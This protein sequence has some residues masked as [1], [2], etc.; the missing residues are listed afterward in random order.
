MEPETQHQLWTCR[1]LFFIRIL[2]WHV[3]SEST[4]LMQG[5]CDYST[6]KQ[7]S[8]TTIVGHLFLYIYCRMCNM[9]I[10]SKW[11]KKM[12]YWCVQWGH[13]SFDCF[14]PYQGLK[15]AVRL[16]THC[17]RRK[18]LLNVIVMGYICQK[19]AIVFQAM[20][21]VMLLV[22][23]VRPCLIRLF[24][25]SPA[26][27]RSGGLAATVA[28]GRFAAWWWDQKGTIFVFQVIEKIITSVFS[29]TMSHSLACKP[30]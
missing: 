9:C 12:R 19:G 28:D 15:E 6:F 16:C 23:S 5:M 24:S 26:I 3:T 29:E 14:Q 1:M 11:K 7:G 13:V 22:C 8:N 10:S 21:K 20:E 2:R 18:V 30:Y 4:W 27:G 17:R 25:L